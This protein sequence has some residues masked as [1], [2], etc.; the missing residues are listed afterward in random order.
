MQ[1]E[2]IEP[3]DLLNLADKAL[4]RAKQQGRDQVAVQTDIRILSFTRYLNTL[5][6]KTGTT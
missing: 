6:P 1:E 5:E 4:Y 3:D 2:E